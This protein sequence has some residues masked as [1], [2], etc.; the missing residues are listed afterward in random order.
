M[1]SMGRRLGNIAG[2][3]IPVHVF[4][5]E[6]GSIVWGIPFYVSA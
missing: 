3:R 2:K 5:G 4:L 1:G 6:G